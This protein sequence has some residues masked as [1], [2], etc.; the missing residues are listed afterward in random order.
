VAHQS[1]SAFVLEIEVDAGVLSFIQTCFSS[2]NVVGSFKKGCFSLGIFF[3]MA[4]TWPFY[5]R[6]EILD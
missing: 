5:L 3:D 1:K 4:L 2:L 6:F